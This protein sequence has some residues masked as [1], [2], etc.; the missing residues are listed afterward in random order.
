MSRFARYRDARVLSVLAIAGLFWLCG[1][2]VKAWAFM[3]LI[4]M[5]H[6]E[7]GTPPRTVGFLISVPFVLVLTLLTTRIATRVERDEE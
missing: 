4:G 5:L 7:T 6:A 1:L 2:V 3:I